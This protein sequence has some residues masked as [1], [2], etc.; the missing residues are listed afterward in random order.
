MFQW[1][2]VV[3]QWMNEQSS[4]LSRMSSLNQLKWYD[5]MKSGKIKTVKIAYSPW[6]NQ[7]GTPLKIKSGWPV[8]VMRMSSSS[9]GDCFK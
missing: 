3:V 6:Y 9:A 2:V 7:S 5:N 4:T 8:F 1:F